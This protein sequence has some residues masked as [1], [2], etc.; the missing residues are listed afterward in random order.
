[1]VHENLMV[2]TGTATPELAAGVAA[3]LG[4]PILDEVA[5]SWQLENRGGYTVLGAAIAI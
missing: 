3:E 5:F 2:F 1:M 4:I